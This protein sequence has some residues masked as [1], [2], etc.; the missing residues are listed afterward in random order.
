[1]WLQVSQQSCQRDLTR[2]VT[3]VGW[4]RSKAEKGAEVIGVLT[5]QAVCLLACPP[6]CF[7]GHLPVCLSTRL[8]VGWA[9]C[10]VTVSFPSGLPACDLANSSSGRP[11]GNV[12]EHPSVYAASTSTPRYDSPALSPLY[13]P[14]IHT[15]LPPPAPPRPPPITLTSLSPHSCHRDTITKQTCTPK[16]CL[17]KLDFGWCWGR[18]EKGRD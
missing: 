15:S 17:V 18:K 6:A 8:T 2:F 5:A 7:P 10:R 9:A 3:G 1:M 4:V 11:L 13:L 16:Y 14:S 12:S